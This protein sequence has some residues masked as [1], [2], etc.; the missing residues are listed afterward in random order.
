MVLTICLK[1]QKHNKKY[2]PKIHENASEIPLK[3]FK[4]KHPKNTQ[5]APNISKH[6]LFIYIYNP[7]KKN[8]LK[9]KKKYIFSQLSSSDEALFK[10]S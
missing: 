6:K 7:K 5:N 9:G 8:L 3:Y 4:I 1:L 10:A 2:T